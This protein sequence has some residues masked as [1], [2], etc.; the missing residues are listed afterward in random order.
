MSYHSLDTVKAA[1]DSY[2][3][4]RQQTID[5]ALAV[6]DQLENESYNH[7]IVVQSDITC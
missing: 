5:D 4:K 2:R 3:M 6:M 7:A 1:R